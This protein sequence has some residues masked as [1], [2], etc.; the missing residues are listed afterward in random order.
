MEIWALE[1]LPE[2]AYCLFPFAVKEHRMII[3]RNSNSVSK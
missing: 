1:I 2:V 3:T